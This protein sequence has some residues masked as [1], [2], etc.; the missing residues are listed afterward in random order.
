MFG[1]RERFLGC[2]IVTGHS[3]PGPA[4]NPHGHVIEVEAAPSPW[5]RPLSRAP[6][7]RAGLPPQDQSNRAIKLRAFARLIE[8][9]FFLSTPQLF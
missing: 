7:E 3:R 5:A 4:P 2:R 6:V 8:R 1:C 9:G